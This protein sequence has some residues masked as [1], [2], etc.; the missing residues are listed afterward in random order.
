MDSSSARQLPV[1]FGRGLHGANAV[2]TMRPRTRLPGSALRLSSAGQSNARRETIAPRVAPSSIHLHCYRPSIRYYELLPTADHRDVEVRSAHRGLPP[3]E[4]LPRDAELAAP[5]LARFIQGDDD[6]DAL[7][8]V[9]AAKA[10]RPEACELLLEFLS[11]APARRGAV[12]VPAHEPDALHE[13][14]GDAEGPEVG[15]VP[16]IPQQVVASVPSLRKERSRRVGAIVARH[17]VIERYAARGQVEDR[18]VAGVRVLEHEARRGAPILLLVV[19]V[20][21]AKCARRQDEYGGEC[22]RP[23]RPWPQADDSG[24]SENDEARQADDEVARDEDGL[25]I[26]DDEAADDG[27]G[28]RSDK[29]HPRP[30]VA[31]AALASPDGQGDSDE[32][33]VHEQEPA[34][35]ARE[36]LHRVDEIAYS[37]PRDPVDLVAVPRRDEQNQRR[38]QDAHRG[39][40]RQEPSPG[41]LPVC[42]YESHELRGDRQEGE[43]VC[44]EG[45]DA[46]HGV[47]ERVPGGRLVEANDEEVRRERD[48]QEN[49]RVAARFLRVVDEEG[50]DGEEQCGNEH[51]GLVE[52]AR[53]ERVD[54]RHS[55]DG[56]Q[57]REAPNPGLARAEDRPE[58]EQDVVQAHIRLALD[59]HVPEL[60]PARAG[61]RDAVRLVSP[62]ALA[63]DPGQAEEGGE[64][65][66]N[67][68][69]P[70]GPPPHRLSPASHADAR[71]GQRGTPRRRAY[72]A[73]RRGDRLPAGS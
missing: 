71:G 54:S 28:D 26:G 11:L 65:E 23:E 39:E 38:D 20:P 5:S 43:E 69:R 2:R 72:A 18:G 70:P 63:P 6:A 60:A 52:E 61:E 22:E 45:R 1:R 48:Q 24:C 25:R 62:Q 15:N 27:K 8:R 53:A 56:K 49:E 17:V 58:L 55:T 37:R 50:V 35:L 9:D 34:A 3:E 47:R 59:D 29:E 7:A 46:H 66:R 51:S 40:P 30:T 42:N 36:R 19:V 14:V 13:S 68:R 67:E 73:V 64:C 57:R 33:R 44:V 31:T 16:A 4:E 21:V 32:D 41:A 10:A 12:V